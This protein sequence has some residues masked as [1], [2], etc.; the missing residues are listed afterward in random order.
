V[1]ETAAAAPL[2][3]RQRI[4]DSAYR[5]FARRGI[6]GVAMEEIIEDAGVARATVY[7]HFR[8]KDE[9]A[10]AFLAQREQVWTLGLV[11]LEARRRAFTPEE[12]LLAIFDVFDDWFRRDDFEACSFINVLLEMGADHAA[13]KACIDYLENIRA[14][15]RGLADE[16]GLRDTDEFARSWHIL[17]K[18]SIISAAEGDLDAARRAK[19]MARRLIEEHR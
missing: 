7:R 12:R 5:L 19:S 14:V 3:A 8:S 4:L 2:P 18:G 15:V 11:E 10:L 13:G 1:T 9:L 16:A 17:M 6:R